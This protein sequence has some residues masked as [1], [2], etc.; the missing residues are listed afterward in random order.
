MQLRLLPLYKSFMQHGICVEAHTLATEASTPS[1]ATLRRRGSALE[2]DRRCPEVAGRAYC[3]LMLLSTCSGSRKVLKQSQGFKTQ[4]LPAS[5]PQTLTVGP[6]P[7]RT[8]LQDHK[9]SQAAQHLWRPVLAKPELL[10]FCGPESGVAR[11]P[12]NLGFVLAILLVQ[13]S[14]RSLSVFSVEPGRSPSSGEV[15]RPAFRAAKHKQFWL[16]EDGPPQ[17]QFCLTAAL[18]RRVCSCFGQAPVRSA[19][20][21]CAANEIQLL[22]PTG[23]NS[24]PKNGAVSRFQKWCREMDQ[25]PQHNLELNWRRKTATPKLGPFGDPSFGVANSFIFGLNLSRLHTPGDSGPQT[26]T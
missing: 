9:F 17:L 26:S 23:S 5:H 11:L 7:A 8:F 21:R 18:Q 12:R 10:V 24:V 22:E 13:L 1:G 4:T 3:V 19:R 20:R 14:C 2:E 6:Y 25:L 16:R 15:G